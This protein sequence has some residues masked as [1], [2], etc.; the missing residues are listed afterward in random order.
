M[1][2][3]AAA[4]LVAI[5]AVLGLSILA[6]WPQALHM[7]T[8]LASHHDTYFSV[9][10]L[11]WIAHA[12]ATN[13]LHLFDANIFHPAKGT[14]AYSD[15]ML[16]E[17]VV[18]AP[19]FWIG[20]SPV[21]I[22]NV[23]LIA[24]Y[25]GSGLAMFLLVRYLT[26]ATGPALVS[27]A[28][29]TMAP[30]RLEHA[31]HLELQWA[32]WMPLTFW[33]LHRAVEDPSPRFGVLAGLFAWLQVV[34]CVYYGL[35]LAIV[36]VVAVPVLLLVTRRGGIHAWGGLAIGALVA[37]VLTVPYAWPYIEAGRTVG[38][39]DPAEIARYSAQPFNYLSSTSLSWLWGWTADR[40][41]SREL[42][43]FPGVVATALAL[44]GVTGASWRRSIVYIVVAAVAV[45][46]SF[47]THGALYQW[48]SARTDALQG[49]R[50]PARF[51]IVAMC[52]AAVLA[53][54]GV[55]ALV[56]RR[57]AQGWGGKLL[58]P[59]A[60]GLVVADFGGRPMPLTTE[61]LGVRTPIY[62]AMQSAG[63]GVVVELPVP[64]PD[65]LPGWDAYYAAWS[66]TH[67]HPLVNGYSGYHP[68]DYLQLLERMRTFPDARSI[69]GLRGHDVRYIV[70]HR[71]LMDPEQYTQLMLRM[72]ARGELKSWGSYK[73]PRGNA[74][75]FV[76][77]P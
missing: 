56:R 65:Q 29:F 72:G 5:A 33:A 42:R 49:F 10:R 25:A 19:F 4:W 54:F 31:M 74:D 38:E 32:M 70:V 66:I 71:S 61:R 22:Y 17:G 50:S 15:A 1:I 68:P 51:A 7:R 60:L 58:V 40:W 20:L 39:R 2:R 48:L 9:W 53:G 62:Q 34:S 3:R 69:T 18:A 13:P 64:T 21:L 44:I 43:L 30:Y 8:A 63:P 47:G 55:D 73:D 24:G 52:G 36:L 23:L 76:L 45:E 16:L 14:L 77:E 37:L 57:F 75:L 35:F 27:A 12:L 67:W 6:T 26:G 11:A 46:C 41:G 28:I 59:L